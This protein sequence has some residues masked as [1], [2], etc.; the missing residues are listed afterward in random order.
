MLT[1]RELRKMGQKGPGKSYRQGISLLDLADMFP[2]E[3]AAVKW[4]EYWHWPDGEMACM[5][6]GSPNCYRVK[7]GK[8]MPYRCRECKK[9]FS[10]KTNTAM[11]A[12]NLPLRKWV[13]AIYL[14]ITNLKGV[15]SMKLHRDQASTSGGWRIRTASRAFGRCY[16]EPTTAPTTRFRPSISSATSTSSRAGTTC[17]H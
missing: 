5:R 11:E 8:P 13:Y 7:S 16:A 17:A 10:L 15:S 12:S 6:C 2:D 1:D 14:E 4:F 3:E 9:Y